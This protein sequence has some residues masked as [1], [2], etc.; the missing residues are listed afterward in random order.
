MKGRGHASQDSGGRRTFYCNWAW[1]VLVVLALALRLGAS[2]AQ[3]NGVVVTGYSI[4]SSHDYYYRDPCAWHLLGSNDGGQ[5]WTLLDVRADEFFG[6]RNRRRTFEITNSSAFTTYRLQID[7]LNWW[8]AE[9]PVG[10]D[11]SVQLAELELHTTPSADL[12]QYARS[13]SASA[14]HPVLGDPENAFDNDVSTRWFDFGLSHG[15]ECWIQCE[16]VNY[17][18]RVVRTIQEI[19]ALARVRLLRDSIAARS[20]R[21]VS[22]LTH[23]GVTRDRPLIGYALTSANDVSSRDPRDWVLLG[24]RDGGK[25]WEKLDTR[26]HEIFA[27][28]FQRRVFALQQPGTHP[29]VRLQIE[30]VNNSGGPAQ[31][32]EVEPLYSPQEV[33]RRDS[34]V[35]SARWENP[36]WECAEMAFDSDPK[37]K[38]FSAAAVRPGEPTWIQWQTIPAFRHRSARVQPGS[39]VWFRTLPRTRSNRIHHHVRQRR[40]GS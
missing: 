27:S 25:S 10:E 12:A 38:W 1:R 9:T 33:G 21:I 16:F 29:L 23:Q 36:P 15:E 40:P 19:R 6:G 28:R 2:P 31:L 5:S 11:T 4:I 39:T 3:S 8:A 24:S 35:V 20:D 13:Y 18:E 17:T 26:Q 34:V 37:T 7:D 22:N 14:P 30:A 32:A